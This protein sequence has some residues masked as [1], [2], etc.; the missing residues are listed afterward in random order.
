MKEMTPSGWGPRGSASQCPSSRAGLHAVPE[1]IAS[2]SE[3][4]SRDARD[5]LT[6]TLAHSSLSGMAIEIFSGDLPQKVSD[7]LQAGREG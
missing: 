3:G 7:R 1:E 2:C 4:P 6:P 5:R